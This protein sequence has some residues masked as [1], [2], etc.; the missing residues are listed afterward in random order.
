M[1]DCAFKAF[2]NA[3]FS[4]ADV[5]DCA[6]LVDVKVI[7]VRPYWRIGERGNLEGVKISFNDI[8]A[9][10]VQVEIIL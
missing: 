6:G 8:T 3:V 5:D 9:E 2:S 4:Q 7:V 10:Q 1:I